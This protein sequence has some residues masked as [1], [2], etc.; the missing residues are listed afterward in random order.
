MVPLR[1]RWEAMDVID[2][3]SAENYH[4]IEYVCHD[5]SI[6]RSACGSPRGPHA[7]RLRL[8]TSKELLAIVCWC[9][10]GCAYLSKRAQP[11]KNA[12]TDPRGVLALSRRRDADLHVLDCQFLDL[13][14]QSVREILAQ[15]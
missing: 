12:T 4:D 14:H 2:T 5:E 6:M 10:A 8:P 15:C 11:G 9:G 1:S 13:A 7:I 3:H